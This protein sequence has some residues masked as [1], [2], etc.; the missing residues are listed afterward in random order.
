MPSAKKP[1]PRRRRAKASARHP[2]DTIFRPRSVAVIGASRRKQ[3]IGRETLRNLID[4][5]F[6]GPVYPV[7]PSASVVHSMQ[8]HRSIEEIPGPVDLAVIVVPR[9]HVLDVV[10]QCGRKGV[11]GLVVISAGFRE[12]DSAGAELERQLAEKLAHYGMRMVGPNCMG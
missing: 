11:G 6:T 3:T 2:L 4:F 9:D 7:N 5:E 8:A 1:S 12:V 10:D